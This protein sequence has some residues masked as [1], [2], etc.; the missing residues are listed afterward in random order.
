MQR[1][2]CLVLCP[3][4]NLYQSVI[5]D[6]DVHVSQLESCRYVAERNVFPELVDTPA[7]KK[8]CLASETPRRRYTNARIGE[9]P[10]ESIV[11]ILFVF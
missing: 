7:I 1:P 10:L 3:I 4:P 8:P 2:S 9:G 5:N 11:C 6:Q